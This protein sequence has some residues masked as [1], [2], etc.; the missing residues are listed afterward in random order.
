MN[1]SFEV[2]I[3]GLG[4]M[5][6]AAAYHL[7]RCGQRVLGLDCFAPPHTFG[8][9]HGQTRIIREAYFEH[10]L[11][12][13][14]VK[15]AYELWAELERECAQTLFRQTG[16]LMIGPPDGV[17][18]KGAQHSAELH[19]LP[20]TMLSADE[21]RRRF[22]AFHPT[23]EMVAVWEPRAGILFPEACVEAHL[24][25]ARERG[26]TL[27]FEEPITHWQA[28]GAGVRV[29]TSRGDYYADRLL[30]AV[31][32]WIQT[33]LA[34][35]S[36]PLVIER[37]AFCLF[38]PAAHA[39]HFHPD[40]CPINLWEYA[41]DRFFYGFPDLGQGVKAAIHHE[42]EFI[43]PETVKRTVAPEEVEHI[44]AFVRRFLPDANGELR[45]S[46]VCLY[47]N[48]PDSHFLIDFHPRHPQVL[49]VSPC[50]GHGFKFS[51]V[52]G[53]VLADLCLTGHSSF[54]LRPFQLNRMSRA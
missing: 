27:Q 40:H 28:D 38:E 52:M 33:L 14:L 13:P 22:P 15:R 3:A 42:G 49:I 46:T 51:S 16:G 25:L 11:Y 54:D 45:H 23:D 34:D 18:V 43:D 4:A 37:Q 53:E 8:S 47:T 5:G 30:L 19:Q 7:A 21:I 10:P 9:S 20:H 1:Q 41:P 29:R 35:L 17:L 48:T 6:S 24:K 26:A 2:I 50:S 31:G 36:L 39:E 12:V 44:R 32:P